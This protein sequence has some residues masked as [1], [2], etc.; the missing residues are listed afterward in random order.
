MFWSKVSFSRTNRDEL[1]A[2]IAIFG[3]VFLAIRPVT[4]NKGQFDRHQPWTVG[5]NSKPYGG[6]ATGHGVM[7]AGYDRNKDTISFVTWDG[8]A[9]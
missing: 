8:L 2:A 1:H 5:A 3:F 7:A 6:P 4:E 9:T